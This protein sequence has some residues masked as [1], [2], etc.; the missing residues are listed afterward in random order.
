[1][2]LLLHPNNFCSKTFETHRLMYENS[3]SFAY[4]LSSVVRFSKKLREGVTYK[5]GNWHALSHEQYFLKHHFSGICQRAFKIK[6]L[7]NRRISCKIK[8]PRMH[9]YFYKRHILLVTDTSK[10]KAR[11]QF[12][13][14]CQASFPGQRN[15]YYNFMVYCFYT[16]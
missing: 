2:S 1:M 11:A 6:F 12:L 16:F 13:A 10:T 14:F 8:K 15:F 5:V 7:K 3:N 9:S 4:E